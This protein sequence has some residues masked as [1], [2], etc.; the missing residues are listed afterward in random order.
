MEEGAT[1][2]YVRD[3]RNR[4]F[5]GKISDKEDREG[6]KARRRHGLCVLC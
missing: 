6:E 4:Y 3:E 1:G 2:D 5:G